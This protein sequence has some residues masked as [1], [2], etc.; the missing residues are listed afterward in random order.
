MAVSYPLALPTARG[1]AQVTIR[2][3]K[4]VGLSASPFAALAQ[5]TYEWP[6]NELWEADIALPAMVRADAAP[7]ISF[8]VSLD[9]PIGTFLMG[10]RSATQPRGAAAQTP[11]TPQVAVGGAT[12]KE[13]AIKT[14][15][16]VVANY[17]RAGDWLQ[18]GAAGTSRLYMV[19]KDVS[20]AADGHATVDIRPALRFAT[21]VNET[22]VLAAPKGVWRLAGGTSE[23]MVDTASHYKAATIKAV[24]APY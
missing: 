15:L 4:I 17:L 6:G 14:G 7:W 18:L 10:D 1:V 2:H 8:L 20:L 21:V 11:G 9:G 12:G 24:E 23:Y 13:L 22:I 3:R 16:G 19:M 5:Q